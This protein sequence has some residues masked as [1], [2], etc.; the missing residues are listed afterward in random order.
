[1]VNVE[2]AN[3]YMRLHFLNIKLYTDLIKNVAQSICNKYILINTSNPST[4]GIKANKVVAAKAIS[5]S[6][7]TDKNNL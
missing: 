4:G 3:M 5:L 1:M 2:I 7:K 6:S